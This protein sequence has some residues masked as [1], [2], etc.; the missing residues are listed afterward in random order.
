MDCQAAYKFIR[1][2]AIH[3]FMFNNELEHLGGFQTSRFLITPRSL[4]ESAKFERIEV[5][6][7]SLADS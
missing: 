7:P 2:I 3:S 4:N 1:Q 6:V 5:L